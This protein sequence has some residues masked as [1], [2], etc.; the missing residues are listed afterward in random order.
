MVTVRVTATAT[1]T[2]TMEVEE[3]DLIDQSIR[4]IVEANMTTFGASIESID[5]LNDVEVE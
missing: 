5:D 1:V 2:F 4:E 3:E